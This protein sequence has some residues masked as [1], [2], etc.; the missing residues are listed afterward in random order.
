MTFRQAL[1]ALGLGTMVLTAGRAASGEGL[2][3]HQKRA[4]LAK[5]HDEALKN[6]PA[7]VAAKVE[8]IK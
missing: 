3:P 7:C 5:V 8:E 4:E 1:G 6:N 2:T